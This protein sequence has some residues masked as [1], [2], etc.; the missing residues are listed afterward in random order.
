MGKYILESV[1]ND[2]YLQEDGSFN[3]ALH[4]AKQVSLQE[5]TTLERSLRLSGTPTYIRIY[6]DKQ[7][8]ALT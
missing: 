1:L 7:I 6:T 3:E 8:N 2:T 5:A 4:T